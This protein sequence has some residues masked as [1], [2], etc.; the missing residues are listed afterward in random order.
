MYDCTFRIKHKRQQR[1]KLF[2]LLL[3]GLRT[4]AALPKYTLLHAVELCTQPGHTNLATNIA[5]WTLTLVVRHPL[6]S[7]TVQRAKFAN[8]AIWS[9][10][11]HLN[12]LSS[13]IALSVSCLCSLNSSLSAMYLPLR[14]GMLVRMARKARWFAYCKTQ[15]DAVG[16]P[17]IYCL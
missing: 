7:V 9:T 10:A 13:V 2:F 17:V 4:A 16:H 14:R 3:V 5:P 11:L 1:Q 8:F 15:L 6:S 12:A